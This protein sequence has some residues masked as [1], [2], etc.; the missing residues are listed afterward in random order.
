MSCSPACRTTPARTA[1]P[2]AAY[3]NA[4]YLDVEAVPDLAECPEMKAMVDAPA[5]QARLRT[6]RAEPRVDYPGVAEVKSAVLE[7]L[8]GASGSVTWP[9][10][11]TGP[12]PSTPSAPSA[13]R[14]CAGR[15]SSTRSW[16]TSAGRIPASGAGR[17]GPEPTVIRARPKCRPSWQRTSSGWSISNTCSGWPEQ[18]AAGRRPVPGARPRRRPGPRPGGRRGRG[19]RGHLG[20]EG[21]DR[22]GRQRGAPPDEINRM[23]QDW[24][25]PPWIRAS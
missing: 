3:F 5:F 16:R 25:L 12:G 8:T 20:A 10:T 21:A 19:R 23:G 4:L 15:R 17:R 13:A 11:A 24:G 22:A 7:G 1:R 2:A 9:S 6:L 18:L 14:A